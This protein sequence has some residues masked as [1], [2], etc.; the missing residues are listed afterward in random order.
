MSIDIKSKLEKPKTALRSII[1]V[2]SSL[3][4][5]RKDTWNAFIDSATEQEIIPILDVLTN[6]ADALS[7][8]TENLIDKLQATK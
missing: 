7:F 5:A 4:E 2:S 1:V 8:L 3:S 6:D